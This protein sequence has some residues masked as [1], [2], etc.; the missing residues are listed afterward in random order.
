MMEDKIWAKQVLAGNRLS[1]I[2]ELQEHKATERQGNA[3]VSKTHQSST[4]TEMQ[5]GKKQIQFSTTGKFS[6]VLP[7]AYSKCSAHSPLKGTPW[8]DAALSSVTQMKS[9]ILRC[10]RGLKEQEHIEFWLTFFG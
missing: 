1:A 10:K 3:E 2:S 6:A 9:R 4:A 7:A 8:K 5:P